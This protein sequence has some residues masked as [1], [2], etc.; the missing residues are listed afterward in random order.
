MISDIGRWNR[1][2]RPS[3]SVSAA[4]KWRALKSPVF[5]STR[6]SAWSCG[7][8][9][10]RWIS[11]SGVIAN[12]TSH[13]L[14]V[15]KAARTTPSA[16]NTSSV[17]RVWYEK[18]WRIGCPCTQWIMGAISAELRATKTID[19]ATPAAAKRTSSLGITLWAFSTACA[20]AHAPIVAS[21]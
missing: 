3:S 11:K 7:T 16:A 10:A 4:A 5:G 8:D 9:R 14:P 20:T 2:E 1:C 21:V 19:A 18:I 15:Q 13:G 6:A 17:E 12:G